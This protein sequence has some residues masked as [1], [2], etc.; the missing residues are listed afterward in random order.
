MFAL[1]QDAGLHCR[2]GFPPWTIMRQRRQESKS[3]AYSMV[4]L[5]CLIGSAKR[6]QVMSGV[7]LPHTYNAM[8]SEAT[9]WLG[10]TH[11]LHLWTNDVSELPVASARKAP[12]SC[13]E[14]DWLE[15][16]VCIAG[17]SMKV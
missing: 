1:S 4:A 5:A 17:R 11:V 6:F 10:W 16:R 15:Y 13:E 12:S 2:C 7:A 8:N 9:A 14:H 3:R